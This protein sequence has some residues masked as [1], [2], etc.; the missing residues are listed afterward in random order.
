MRGDLVVWLAIAAGSALGGVARHLVTEAAARSWGTALP[1][2]TW[3]V[4]VSGSAAI[5]ALTA[6][7]AASWPAA[8]S[9]TT[10]HAALTGVLGGFT[11]FSTFSVQTMA[12]LQQGQWMAALAY[13]ALSLVVGVV[14]CWMAFAGVQ[15]LLR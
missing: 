7:A 11:T 10:R 6:M 13:A 2:G 5:G 1:W 15:A 12:L 8:W 3:L 4:N 14:S 9:V